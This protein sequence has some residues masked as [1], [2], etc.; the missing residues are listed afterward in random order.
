MKLLLILLGAYLLVINLEGFALMGPSGALSTTLWNSGFRGRSNKSSPRRKTVMPVLRPTV[1]RAE[2][3][4]NS[5]PSN[6]SD[7]DSASK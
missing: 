1:P 6:G 5:K 3:A 7:S 4:S 2:A